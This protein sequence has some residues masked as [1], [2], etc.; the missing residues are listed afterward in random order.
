MTARD[1][2]IFDDS[3]WF[4]GGPDRLG[5]AR[6]VPTMLA[7]E[8]ELLLHWLTAE[9]AR[10]DGAVVD[11]G[12]FAGGSTARLAEGQK[13][14]GHTAPI[15]AWDRFGADEATKRRWLYPAGVAPFEGQ[16]LLPAATA[17]LA[18]WAD[19]VTLHQ[20]DLR[21]EGWDG[22]P[23][24]VLVIDASKS[25]QTLDA[26]ARSFYPALRPGAVIVQC[27][28]LHW[29]E[30]WVVAQMTLLRDWVTPVAHAHDTTLVYGVT[31]AMD[32]FAVREG[33]TTGLRDSALTAIL[34]SARPVYDDFALTEHLDTALAGIARSPG[35]RTAW[36]MV[37]D[38]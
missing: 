8:E 14:A 11:L 27:G 33:L 12:C 19:R 34:K 21:E 10:G 16:D 17:F 4:P 13:T 23:I 37:P 6:A 15:H 25:T 3:P 2:S 18:P 28:A 36:K 31:R 30:P 20:G 29:R 24:E 5:H 32:D 9:W 38:A 35:I 7:H 1:F 22:G 26:I